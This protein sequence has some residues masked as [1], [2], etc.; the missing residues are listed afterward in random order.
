MEDLLL[1]IAEWMAMHVEDRCTLVL[2]VWGQPNQ[3]WYAEIRGR[4]KAGYCVIAGLSTSG[5]SSIAEAL[6]YLRREI[7][8]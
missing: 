6:E 8:V 1:Q 3:K 2:A 7:T 4:H 5:A